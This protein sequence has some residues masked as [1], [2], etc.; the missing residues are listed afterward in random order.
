MY[1]QVKWNISLNDKGEGGHELEIQIYDYDP[2]PKPFA[3]IISLPPEL[4][5]SKFQS[6]ANNT[7]IY[8]SDDKTIEI[9]SIVK[10]FPIPLPNPIIVHCK[11][12]TEKFVSVYDDFTVLSLYY[13]IKDMKASS[14][15][16]L[17]TLPKIWILRFYVDKYLLKILSFLDLSKLF[18]K[19]GLE[20]I[21]GSYKVTE[22]LGAK[23]QRWEI[24]DSGSS[25]TLRF[26]IPDGAFKT[27]IDFS[28]VRALNPF[29]YLISLYVSYKL[30]HW[31]ASIIW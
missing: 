11:F 9:S 22:A 20:N 28:Y 26:I 4:N 8:W 16:I 12:Y 3:Q 25:P 17:I 21:I 1:T 14:I 18:G 23:V 6:E 7:K 31:L 2:T 19:K 30:L 10:A 13:I 5:I 29:W 15:N 24:L 27:N